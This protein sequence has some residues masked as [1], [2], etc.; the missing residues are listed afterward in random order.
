VT[1]WREATKSVHGD[2]T[3]P[4]E[5]PVTTPIAQTST[6][7]F[8]DTQAIDDLYEGRREGHAYSRYS[9]PTVASAARRV[10]VLE[11]G[12]AGILTASGMGAVTAIVLAHAKAGGRILAVQDTY[13]GTTALFERILPRFGVRV[14]RFPTADAKSLER[15]LADGGADLVWLESPTNPTLRLVDLDAVSAIARDAGVPTAIDSTFASPI[16]AK[17]LAHG[18]DVVM[19]SATKYLGGHADLTLGAIVA[20]RKRLAAIEAV[21]RT[22]GATPDPHAAFLLERG[23]KTLELRV[24]RANANAQSLAEWLERHPKVARVHYPGLLS[25]PQHALARRVMPGGGGGVVSFDLKAGTKAAAVAFAD[26]LRLVRNAASLGGVE[27]LVTL[28][29]VQS[30]RSLSPQ[31]LAASGITPGTVRLACGVEDVGD[32]RADLDQALAKVP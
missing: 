8:L 6:F 17:P 9:N 22:L 1:T 14:D 11:G 4:R 23:L 29:V 12:E 10:A 18:I 20:S 7:G 30:H 28:P 19:H 13:G 3:G 24:K 21:A 27:S 2:D 31:Q 32:L 15:A 25:H 16:N 5:G 26:A